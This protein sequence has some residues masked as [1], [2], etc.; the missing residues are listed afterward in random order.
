MA[1]KRR[2]FHAITAPENQSSLHKSHVAKSLTTGRPSRRMD[3]EISCLENGCCKVKV[4]EVTAKGE[5]KNRVYSL[6]DVTDMLHSILDKFA[7]DKYW[8]GLFPIVDMF[9]D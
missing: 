1:K 3:V 5:I 4:H 2:I 7:K 6:S 9:R 8:K